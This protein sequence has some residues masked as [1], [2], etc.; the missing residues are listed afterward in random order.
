M[1]PVRKKTPQAQSAAVPAPRGAEPALAATVDELGALEV[2]LLPWK[3]KLKRAEAL[4]SLL[5]ERFEGEP[6]EKACEARGALF[7]ASLGPKATE[8]T[9]DV[10]KLAKAI[11]LKALIPLAKVTLNAL[12]RLTDPPHVAAGNASISSAPTGARPLQLFERPKAA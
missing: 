1:T 5:R 8:R 10:A 7:I 12:T 6:A 4:R 11:G 2:E 3:A 9:V